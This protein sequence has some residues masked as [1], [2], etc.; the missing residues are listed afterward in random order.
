MIEKKFLSF[1][2]YYEGQLR[3]TINCHG[4]YGY[5]LSQPYAPVSNT[6]SHPI[7]PF[8]GF[9]EWVSA[10]ELLDIIKNNYITDRELTEFKYIRLASCHSADGLKKGNKEKFQSYLDNLRKSNR[11]PEEE[12]DKLKKICSL[13]KEFSRIIPSS[14]IV[15]GYK[16]TLNTKQVKYRENKEDVKKSE[17]ELSFRE[18]SDS[19]IMYSQFNPD[20]LHPLFFEFGEEFYERAQYK[21]KKGKD[22]HEKVQNKKQALSKAIETIES[23]ASTS[24]LWRNTSGNKNTKPISFCNGRELNIPPFE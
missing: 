22:L 14:I 17:F 16:G 21:G 23:Q 2:D 18:G 11:V 3:L 13:A 15:Q 8:K 5:M 6:P 19:N 7:E 10:S 12:L 24:V 20:E 4:Y 1:E 9:P